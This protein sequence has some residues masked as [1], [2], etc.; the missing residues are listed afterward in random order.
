M[1]NIQTL[2]LATF[3]F[4]ANILAARI[5]YTSSYHGGIPGPN[6]ELARTNLAREIPDAQAAAILAGMA[7]W[8]RGQYTAKQGRIGVTVSAVTPAASKGGASSVVQDMQALVSANANRSPSPEP[9][10]EAPCPRGQKRD[11]KT[12]KCIVMRRSAVSS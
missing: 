8:S 2:F 6:G 3:L 11:K 7:S 10:P 1:V 9:A 5:T 12:R 4:A